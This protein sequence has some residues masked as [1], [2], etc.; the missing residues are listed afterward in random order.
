[1]NGNLTRKPTQRAAQRAETADRAHLHE[2]HTLS[3]RGLWDLLLFLS[4][5][6]AFY[7]VASVDLLAPLGENLRELLGTPPP[8]KL[9]TLAVSGYT[10]SATIL[11]FSR[12]LSGARPRFK[13]Q[14]LFFRT[15]FFFFY[16]VSNTLG[17]YFLGTFAAGIFLI[18][19]EQL[20]IWSFALKTAP[21][22]WQMFG[23][24]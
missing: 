19:L 4:I 13:W 5:S 22:G 7:A 23:K 8:P 11:I 10:L 14:H 15:V 6:T 18:A 17:D 24:S 20:N 9:T 1:M 16:A 2:L 21:Q 12:I 3:R